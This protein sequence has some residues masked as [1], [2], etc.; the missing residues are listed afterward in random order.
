MGIFDSK[1][2]PIT[3]LKLDTRSEWQIKHLEYT[4]KIGVL[5]E[6]IIIVEP[7]GNSVLETFNLFWKSIIVIMDTFRETENFILIDNY[8]NFNRAS[9]KAR[10]A[11]VKNLNKNKKIAMVVYINLP[12]AL[13]VLVNVG[14]TLNYT[15]YPVKITKT[16]TEAITESIIQFERLNLKPKTLQN[17]HIKKEKIERKLKEDLIGID[18]Q[19]II[20]NPRIIGYIKRFNEYLRNIKWTEYDESL[21]LIPGLAESHPLNTLIET[22]SM[23]KFDITQLIK[24]FTNQEKKL[25]NTQVE[26]KKLNKNLENIIKIRTDELLDANEKLRKL[27]KELKKAK[28]EAEQANKGKA[29]FL[30]SVSHELKVSQKAIS[31]I[32]PLFEKKNIKIILNNKLENTIFTFDSFRILQVFINILSN[33]IKFTP[34]NKKIYITLTEDNENLICS[35]KDEGIGLEEAEL[36]SI[37]EIFKMGKQ[38]NYSSGTGLGLAISKKIINTHKGK[39]WAENGKDNGAIFYFTINKY[40]NKKQLSRIQ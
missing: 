18:L 27:N 32:T 34:N 1:V 22:L 21:H 13:H 5:A 23:I 15:K 26:L 19:E 31:E 11:Y 40:L 33:A 38:S 2:C 3:G 14:I 4:C 25:I 39:I 16:Y 29:I 20:G 35:I 36:V 8:K 7:A 24:D 10:K 9:H 6:S 37:F 28:E 17:F 30:A 12:R